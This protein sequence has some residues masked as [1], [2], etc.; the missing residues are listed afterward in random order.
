MDVY[1]YFHEFYKCIKTCKSKRGRNREGLH[2]I[3][4]RKDSYG[5]GCKSGNRG[6]RFHFLHFHLT[7]PG[8]DME[9]LAKRMTTMGSG[10]SK[11]M[12]RFN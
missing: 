6:N 8:L 5:I 10:P 3:R 2:T 7:K 4:F 9:F 11:K 12:W 1:L